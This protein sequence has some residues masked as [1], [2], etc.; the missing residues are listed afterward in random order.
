MAYPFD[1]A[2][3]P[4]RPWLSYGSLGLSSGQPIEGP[5]GGT[6]AA[7]YQPSYF[8]TLYNQAQLPQLDPRVALE[9]SPVLMRSAESPLALADVVKSQW[10]KP[11][12][13]IQQLYGAYG[14]DAAQK[15]IQAMLTGGQSILGQS[16]GESQFGTRNLTTAQ[17]QAF[18]SQLLGETEAPV[19]IGMG[20][21]FN[22]MSMDLLN[23]YYQL[24]NFNSP[25]N[26]LGMAAGMLSKYNLDINQGILGQIQGAL[27][28]GGVYG[29]QYASRITDALR[30]L[31]L[32]EGEKIQQGVSPLGAWLDQ[33]Y[34]G[35]KIVGQVGS[36][37]GSWLQ[38]G[39][40]GA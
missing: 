15:D 10:D 32:G 21:Y 39:R 37:I 27:G 28:E 29:S 24:S 6:G 23:D 17:R 9:E 33:W 13:A 4:Y 7:S 40:I 34:G 1:M 31:Q 26:Q 8:S 30:S 35:G 11:D 12:S 20:Q 16:L 2:Y 36:D 25:N 5:A 22:P 19:S 14:L 38:M 18:G 3:D